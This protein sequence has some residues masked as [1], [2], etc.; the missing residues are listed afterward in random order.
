MEIA[1]DDVMAV[2]FLQQNLY[3]CYFI[4][5]QLFNWYGPVTP[6]VVKIKGGNY[7]V[8]FDP[9]YSEFMQQVHSGLAGEHAHSLW[10]FL[11]KDLAWIFSRVS[12]PFLCFIV[13][14]QDEV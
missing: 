4:K 7:G 10:L 11:T 8:Q 9:F 12:V 14:V 13:I 1:V 5:G 2:N 6:P 3:Q